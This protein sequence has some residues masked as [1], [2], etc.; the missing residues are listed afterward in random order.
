MYK[1]KL[2]LGALA[3]SLAATGCTTLKSAEE[4]KPQPVKSGQHKPHYDANAPYHKNHPKKG[5]KKGEHPNVYMCEQNTKVAAQYNADTDIATLYITAPTLSLADQKIEL[6][7]AVSG[8]GVR[9][10]NDKNPASIYEWHT[11]NK[12]GILTVTAS[13]NAYNFVCEQKYPH[14]Q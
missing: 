14:Q 12:D 7:R 11:K 8:S 6:K 1:T 10:I 2:I 4:S 5:M 9:Y 3:L 13:G